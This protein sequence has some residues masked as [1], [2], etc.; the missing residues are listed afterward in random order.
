M[1]N[2][3]QRWAYLGSL[4]GFL[5]Y[6]AVIA[7]PSVVPSSLSERAQERERGS[8]DHGRF[9]LGVN[10]VRTLWC[11]QCTS[12]QSTLKP[13]LHLT[14]CGAFHEGQKSAVPSPSETDGGARDGRSLWAVSQKSEAVLHGRGPP[15]LVSGDP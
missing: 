8:D 12:G 13:E 1:I 10:E 9:Q 6:S 5:E 4:P 14:V 7:D 15:A 3:S 11:P 2:C